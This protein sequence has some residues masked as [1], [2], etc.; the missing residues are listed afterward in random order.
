M[1]SISEIRSTF[2]Q[3][4]TFARDAVKK[5][6]AEALLQRKWE[7]LFHKELTIPSAHSFV[8]YYRKMRSKKQHGGSTYSP[9]P[10]SYTMT[11]GL[12]VATYGRFPVEVDT[13]PA[14]LHNLDVY[15]QNSLLKGCGVENSSLTLPVEM[16]RNQVGGKSR[17]TSRKVSRKDRKDRKDRKV[18]RKDRKVSR[19]DRKVSRKNRKVSRKNRRQRGGD[20]L[21][22][23]A[24]RQ[25]I[26]TA[27]PNLLQ[28]ATNAWS[29]ST[30]PVPAPAS[31]VNHAWNYASNG[32]IGLINPGLVTNISSDLTK[33]ANPAPWQ[34]SN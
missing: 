15:Y 31:P 19:K 1:P 11:P 25:F 13:D 23:L 26:A 21:A 9:A 18:S 20:L 27:P 14:S 16:G 4:D 2:Q 22:S 32:T 3:F 33:L 29:G 30:T 10:L 34:T 8:Q 5:P 7:K 17:K 12:N 28:S 24:E 6:S